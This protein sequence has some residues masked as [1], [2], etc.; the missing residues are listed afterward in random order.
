MVRIAY[1]SAHFLQR[2]L[3][4]DQL[5]GS[6]HPLLGQIAMKG[7]VLP[8]LKRLGDGGHTDPAILCHSVQRDLFCQMLANIF[9]NFLYFYEMWSDTCVDQLFT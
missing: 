6:L 4:T 7:S 5:I 1:H 8:L 2:H 3:G 9:F